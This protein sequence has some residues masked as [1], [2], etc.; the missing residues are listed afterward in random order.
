MNNAPSVRTERGFRT[1]PAGRCAP[2]PMPS[3]RSPEP[4]QMSGP[5][6]SEV[7]DAALRQWCCSASSFN[8]EISTN[9]EAQRSALQPGRQSVRTRFSHRM[10]A[11]TS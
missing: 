8:R 3:R 2:E 10:V 9:I 6:G 4:C 1:H 5:D 11:T 7:H